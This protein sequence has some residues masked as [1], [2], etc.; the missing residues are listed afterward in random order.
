MLHLMHMNARYKQIS[1]TAFFLALL[2]AEACAERQ[3]KL[4]EIINWDRAGTVKFESLTVRALGSHRPNPHLPLTCWKYEFLEDGETVP[5]EYCHTGDIGDV[6]DLRI[7]GKRYQVE[8]DAGSG[9][10]ERG[11]RITRVDR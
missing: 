9:K 5:L 2:S 6:R 3:A 1:S 10:T 8:F 7:A 11:H 4:G